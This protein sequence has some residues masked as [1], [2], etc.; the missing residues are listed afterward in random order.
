MRQ[1]INPATGQPFAEVPDTP[2]AEVA[3]AVRRARQAFEEWVADHAGRQGQGA[4]APRGP[5]GGRRRGADQ[6]RGGGDG[7]ARRRLQGR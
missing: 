2:V 6:A 4:A 3:A 5:G 1:L 7:Q